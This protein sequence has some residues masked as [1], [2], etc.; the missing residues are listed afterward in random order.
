MLS[1]KAEKACISLKH[2]LEDVYSTSIEEAGH[3]NT[4]KM[5]IQMERYSGV[6]KP[7]LI[8]K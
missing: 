5:D 1:S 3:S 2:K 4:S 6:Q 8:Y 7:F